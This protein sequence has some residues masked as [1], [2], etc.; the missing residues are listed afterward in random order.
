ML[1]RPNFFRCSLLPDVLVVTLPLMLKPGKPLC[2]AAVGDIPIAVLPGFPTSAIFTF[3]AFVAPVIRARAGLSPEAGETIEATVPVRIG[4]EMG[5]QEFVL[6]ALVLTGPLASKVGS[7]I[8]IGPSAVTVWGIA[9]WPVLL[10]V[11]MFMIAL[12]YYAAPNAKLRSLTSIFPG[13]V[14]AV[15]VWLV[16]SAAF[17]FYVA[18]FGS[19]NKTYGTLGGVIIFLVWM[20]LTNV[21]ILLGAEINAE[22]ERSQQLR[23]DTPG[24]EREIQLKERSEPKTKK[25]SRTA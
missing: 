25:R 9:K 3:H 17:A 16:A 2:L 7:A 5:R 13:A 22:R 23:D 15:V 21:A 19:Y 18:N 24:A 1:T 10:V 8:G 4:S 14:L 12:L 6:V 11:V 20:W